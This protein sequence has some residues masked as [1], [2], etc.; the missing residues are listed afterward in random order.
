VPFRAGENVIVPIPAPNRDPR[1]FVDPNA[2]DLARKPQRHFTFSL[3]Q[4]FC[5]GQALARTQLQEFFSRFTG[6]IT[7]VAMLDDHIEWEPFTAI[8]SMKGLRVRM[9]TGSGTE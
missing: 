4:H 5:L 3:G 8:T 7:A 6:A 9:T 1:A 2:V